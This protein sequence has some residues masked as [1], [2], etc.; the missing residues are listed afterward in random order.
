MKPSIQTEDNKS[1]IQVSLDSIVYSIEETWDSLLFWDTDIY[2]DTSSK[3]K[4][5]IKLDIVSNIA[6]INTEISSV[7]IGV[8][9]ET[10]KPKIT[11]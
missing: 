5:N 4:S 11:I 10:N 8:N 6:K 7:R 2:W 9:T 3:T 1:K